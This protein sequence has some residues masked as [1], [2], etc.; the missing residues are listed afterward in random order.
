[1]LNLLR[2]LKRTIIGLIEKKQRNI[3][4]T[5]AISQNYELEHAVIFMKQQTFIDL[6]NDMVAGNQKI[7]NGYVSDLLLREF[8]SSS[9]EE[10]KNFM[11]FIEG[12]RCMDIGPCVFSP[13]S[14]WDIASEKYIIEPLYEKVNEWQLL[15]FGH[16]AF[17]NMII[18]GQRAEV[19][20][21]ELVG[22]IDGAIYC[23]NVIDH[24]PSWPF[25]LSNIS[26][27]A[28]VGCK[29]LFWSDLDH[30][31]TADDGHYDITSDIK[32]FKRLIIQFGFKIIREYQD[33]Q[34]FG[35][36][37]GCFGEKI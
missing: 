12:K 27:Y 35:S 19:L 2:K 3:K 31:G 16:S 15:N 37:W 22:Y 4:K 20:I 1:M 18:Y 9:L 10:W 21:P 23:R 25:I 32:S 28:A 33:E 30:K 14:G 5:W 24:S 7:S 11:R 29:L 36:N 13:L 26:L 8:F 6:L 17:E 34:R